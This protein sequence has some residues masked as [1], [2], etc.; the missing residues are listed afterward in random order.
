VAPPLDHAILDVGLDAGFLLS[1]YLAAL[2]S[3]DREKTE[4]QRIVVLQSALTAAGKDADRIA[5]HVRAI[6]ML[7]SFDGGHT[8][9][10]LTRVLREREMPFVPKHPRP[11]RKAASRVLRSLRRDRS[12]RRV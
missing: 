2:S 10:Y 5:R 4:R 11:I 9:A 12:S 8:R 3:C 6:E 7:A 1:D